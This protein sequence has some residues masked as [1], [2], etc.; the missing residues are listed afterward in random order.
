MDI[1]GLQAFVSV[2]ENASFSAAADALHLTQPAVS[3]RIASLEN[4]LNNR[5]FDRIGR[6]IQLTE[7]G[8]ALLPRAQNII[9]EVQDSQRA[10]SNLSTHIV[11]QLRIGTSHHIGLHRL[12]PVLRNYNQSFPDVE[13]DMQ[14]L[15]SEQACKAVLHGELELGIVTLP[16]D[17]SDPLTLIPLWNDPLHVVASGEHP[18]ATEKN[19]KLHSLANH[20]A[21]LPARGTFTR[22]VIE[23]ML[24]EDVELKVRL[25]TNY[26]ETIRM[27]VEIGLGWSVLPETMIQP[28]LGLCPIK[29]KGVHL[30][31]Q[32]GIV[33]H[34][35][36]TLSN[37]AQAMCDLLLKMADREQTIK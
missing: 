22:E 26:L 27:M 16:P 8:Q 18:L 15:D 37:A 32:L 19:I 6:Q 14:F 24:P 25:S 23:D 7:A 12:P 3:K 13:L 4:E 20:P 5:L 36:R 10:I 1:S 28:E 30:S 17:N 21:V 2:A 29:I 35:E 33:Y 31:R 11:G 34:T 9:N